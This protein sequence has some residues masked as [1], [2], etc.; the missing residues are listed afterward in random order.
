MHQPTLFITFYNLGKGIDI[1][2][3]SI[4]VLLRHLVLSFLSL[5]Y[6]FNVNVSSQQSGSGATYN[7]ATLE[8]TGELLVRVLTLFVDHHNMR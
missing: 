1:Y 4:L 7:L 8:S 5:Y 6:R 3:V 2:L